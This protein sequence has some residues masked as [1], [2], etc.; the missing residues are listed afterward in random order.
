[1]IDDIS[2]EERAS[3]I[4][5]MQAM[6]TSQAWFFHDLW[7]GLQDQPLLIIIVGS[8]ICQDKIGMNREEFNDYYKV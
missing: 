8:Q 3:L 5:S 7:V 4:V 2:M 6:Y 1:M